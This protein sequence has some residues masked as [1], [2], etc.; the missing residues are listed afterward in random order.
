[1][2]EITEG[3]KQVSESLSKLGILVEKV[4]AEKENKIILPKRFVDNMDGTITDLLTGLMWVQDPTVVKSRYFNWEEAIA[5]CRT[6][7]FGRIECSWRLPTIQEELSIVDYTYGGGK[8]NAIDSN[9]FKNISPCYYWTATPCAWS[10]KDAWV[11]DIKNGYSFIDNKTF[12]HPVHPVCSFK[13]KSNIM[14][15]LG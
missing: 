12:T 14:H 7:S 2:S 1:M 3:F 11:V 6:L 4:I 8:G 13:P 9:F 15:I 5:I 10:E